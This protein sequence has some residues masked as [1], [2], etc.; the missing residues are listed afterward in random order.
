M[1]TEPSQQGSSHA[2][3][4]S[5]A[6]PRAPLGATEVSYCLDGACG[7]PS[8]VT[9]ALRGPGELFGLGSASSGG[10]KVGETMM[11]SESGKAVPY[12]TH[13]ANEGHRHRC[14]PPQHPF[15]YQQQPQGQDI[16]AKRGK[17]QGANA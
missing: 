9:R 8:L 1:V 15:G 10:Q 17:K 12:A 14:Q 2:F 3:S 6:Q 5:V 13:S 7:G 4:A 11:A 16:G